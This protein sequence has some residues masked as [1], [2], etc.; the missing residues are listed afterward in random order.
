[1]TKH[2]PRSQFANSFIDSPNPD[3]C[4]IKGCNNPV[5]ALGLCNKHWRRMR[6]YGS[7]VAVKSHSGL[8]KGMSAEERFW[9]QVKK[10]DGCWLWAGATD[11]DGYGIFR[12]S[13]AG[14]LYTKAHRFSYTLHTGELVPDGKVVMHSCDNPRCVNPDHLSLGTTLDNMLDKVAKGRAKV[15]KGELAPTAILTEEQVR[16]IVLD[17]RPYAQIAADYGV[18]ASTI[19]SIKQKVSWR[20]LEIDEVVHAERIGMRGEKQWSTKLTENDVREIRSSPLSGKELA[21]KFGL[22][23]QAISSIRKRR[24]WK[25]VD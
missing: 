18:K 20:S 16:K 17:P 3:V 11:R 5:L 23:P 15:P 21:E 10:G 19:G 2:K 1:M 25:H 13:I 12:G 14:K 6:Q 24:N 9:H 22:S 7:P 4:C 8:M